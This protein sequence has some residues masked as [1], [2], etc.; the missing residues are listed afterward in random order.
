MKK[1]SIL[2]S[3][4][5]LVS[6]LTFG[7]C[8]SKPADGA[9]GGEGG[10]ASSG[11]SS[12]KGTMTESEIL[13][14]Y[15]LTELN[16]ASHA[17]KMIAERAGKKPKEG[18]LPSD[19]PLEC[20]ISGEQASRWDHTLRSLLEHQMTVAREAYTQDALAYSRSAGFE[21]CSS[22][23]TCGVYYKVI[24]PVPVGQLKAPKEKTAHRRFIQRLEA[25]SSRL[26][27]EENLTCARKQ[28]WFCSSD[29]RNYLEANAK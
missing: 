5:T 16:G 25:K 1:S 18:E 12:S 3:V 22:S 17:L 24:Q 4:V 10:A 20:N 28:N 21:T 8:A 14:R 7:G 23:C 13:E 19:P 27:P 6:A 11:G 15:S 26:S 29:L 2:L 9:S